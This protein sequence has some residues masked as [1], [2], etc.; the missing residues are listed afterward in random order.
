MSLTP[1]HY[2]HPQL[3]R[4]PRLSYAQSPAS[5]QFWPLHPC[6]SP[7]CIPSCFKTHQ[8]FWMKH[9]EA[10]HQ[11]QQSTGIP[12]K[13]VALKHVATSSILPTRFELARWQGYT[14]P[15]DM[16]HTRR[17]RSIC[18]RSCWQN[19]RWGWWSRVDG[20]YTY[21]LCICYTNSA[22]EIHFILLIIRVVSLCI[23]LDILKT[24]MI[25]TKR[26]WEPLRQ[27]NMIST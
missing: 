24:S 5:I 27:Q 14:G 8:K 23:L 11:Q 17:D 6:T 16:P 12:V 1:S 3:R 25:L 9:C 10:H 7:Y 4:L 18:W 26:F 19:M 13:Q 20:A 15:C 22:I 21:W 2:Q